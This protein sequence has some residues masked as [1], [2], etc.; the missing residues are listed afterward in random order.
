M[1]L[2][3]NLKLLWTNREKIKVVST[4][5]DQ[6]KGAYVKSGWKTTEFWITVLTV[7][8]TLSE[9]FKGNLDPKWGTVISA[10][11]ALGFAI[12][13]GFIKSS[14]SL[15]KTPLPTD[16]ITTTTTATIQEPTAKP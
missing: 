6:L 10:A 14:A 4:E 9:T 2:L 13:R 12:V 8:T 7:V 16:T 15:A 5:I 11:S 1:G 3:A